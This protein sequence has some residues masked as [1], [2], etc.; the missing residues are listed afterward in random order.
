MFDLGSE[1]SEQAVSQKTNCER[2]ALVT[3]LEQVATT[4]KTRADPHE[5]VVEGVKQGSLVVV[6][7][8][9]KSGSPNMGVWTSAGVAVAGLGLGIGFTIKAL[10]HESNANDPDFVGGQR[11]V[12][13]AETAEII[14][15]VGYGIAGAAGL[16]AFLLWLIDDDPSDVPIALTPGPHGISG[17][18]VVGRF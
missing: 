5:P 16:T 11:E 12:S 9:P 10:G 18:G 17:V 7:E 6:Q 2:D 13:E 14:S 1:A 3:A 15:F 8:R 4:L